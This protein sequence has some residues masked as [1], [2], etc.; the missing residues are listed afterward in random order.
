MQLPALPVGARDREQSF[1]P[2]IIVSALLSA[3]LAAVFGGGVIRMTESTMAMATLALL[4]VAHTLFLNGTRVT[5][6]SLGLFGIPVRST[7]VISTVAAIA[8]V[9]LGRLYKES[10][11]GLRLRAARE[12]PLSSASGGTHVVRTRYAPGSSARR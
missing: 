11:P 10:G 8:F 1:L 12:D 3:V 4:V 9:L 5:R 7:I 2:A 6:G